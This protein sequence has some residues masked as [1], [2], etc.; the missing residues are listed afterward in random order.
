MSTLTNQNNF[1]TTNFY[2]F[3]DQFRAENE[4]LTRS[5]ILKNMILGR[6]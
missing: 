2:Q 4:C 3:S 6:K 1:G 5:Q